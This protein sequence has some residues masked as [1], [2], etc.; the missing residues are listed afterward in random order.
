MQY[1]NPNNRLRPMESHEKT[2]E[3]K[4]NSSEQKAN[5]FSEHLE[6]VFKPCET[7][8]TPSTEQKGIEDK[9]YLQAPYQIDLPIKKLK[10][11]NVERYIIIRETKSKKVSS[12]RS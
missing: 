4:T 5:V 11:K 10:I 7:S 12:I 8:Q 3:N 6:K 1:A 9:D 2:K